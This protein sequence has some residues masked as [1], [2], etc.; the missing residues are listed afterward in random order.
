[1]TINAPVPS[2]TMGNQGERLGYSS[3]HCWHTR[4]HNRL[5]SDKNE[6]LCTFLQLECG[7]GLAPV[8][9]LQYESA[10][11]G[12]KEGRM[13]TFAEFYCFIKN[14]CVL[15]STELLIFTTYVHCDC[16]ERTC[17]GI[18]YDKMYLSFG[19]SLE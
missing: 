4:V 12:F 10:E 14:R 16:D 7:V 9:T 6:C 15:V 19:G 18:S 5:S 3:R 8:L 1:M 2:A 11:G 17:N 13:Q